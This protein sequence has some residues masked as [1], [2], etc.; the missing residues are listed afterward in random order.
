MNSN[1][2]S[3]FLHQSAKPGSSL[4]QLLSLP[5]LYTFT[6]CGTSMI[7]I[8]FLWKNGTILNANL[9]SGLIWNTVGRIKTE[10]LQV[11]TWC[12]NESSFHCNEDTGKDFVD[13]VFGSCR[14]LT[15]KNKIEYKGSLF[16]Y[17]Q[18][19]WNTGNAPKENTL[20]FFLHGD[21]FKH[22]HD[23]IIIAEEALIGFSTKY[24]IYAKEYNHLNLRQNP[25]APPEEVVKC[26]HNCIDANLLQNLTCGLPV[27]N[28]ELPLCTDFDTTM[29]NY[30]LVVY[31]SLM[32]TKNFKTCQCKRKCNE[33]KYTLHKDDEN[34]NG[35]KETELIL[36]YADETHQTL[37][38]REIYSLSAL[39]SDIGGT[40]GLYLGITRLDRSARE[41][42]SRQQ[43]HAFAS[44]A[45][46]KMNKRVRFLSCGY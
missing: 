20:F 44:L 43:S 8:Y 23:S 3:Q 27:I 13:T 46:M 29:K 45:C 11:S 25:C 19:I 39:L 41:T 42:E 18:V 4:L 7:Q 10:S 26:L 30:E 2:S 22:V 32:M 38:E 14:K 6:L 35:N 37:T 12:L 9:N 34:K 21:T 1:G 28:S 40:I 15:M 31:Y 24:R 17:V 33:I 36:L 16:T 5:N